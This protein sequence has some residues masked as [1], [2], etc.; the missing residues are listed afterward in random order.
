MRLKDAVEGCSNGI[1]GDEPKGDANDT[2]VIRVADFDRLKRKTLPHQ[3][4]RSVP[5]DQR[6]PREL[7]PGDL[8]I[9]KSGGG[10][11]QPVGMVVEFEGETGSVC[12]N[13][14]A[15]MRPREFA[16]GRFLT[17]LHAHLYDRS[18]TKLSIKQST[19]IQNLDSGAYLAER[20]FLPPTVEQIA[21]ASYLDAETVRIDG[22][23][24]AKRKLLDSLVELKSARITEILTGAADN[25]VP[26]G[27]VWIPRI[28]RDWTLKRLKHLGQ[29]R[30]GLAKGKKHDAS[31]ETLE[32]PYM[33]VA[34]VQDGHIDLSN[35]ATLE[36]AADDVERYSLAVGDVLMNEGGDYDKLGRGAVWEGKISP[37][38]H[39]NH[40]FAVR[41]DDVTWAP[42]ISALTRTAYAKFYFMNNSK[43]STNLAS[44]S[45]TNVK[46]WPVV[47]PP[48]DVR[49]QLLEQLTA[50]LKR[51]DDLIVHVELEL[52]AL[53]ELRAATITDAVLGRIDVRDYMKK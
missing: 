8:L 5:F 42:W 26:T 28:P 44:I 2:P 39:Q 51:A 3:T 15:R 53:A 27:D 6:S 49:D 10:E 46:E 19:G 36:V 12:S 30:S 34:N 11:L 22:L 50:E 25:L 37:C 40:V 1:W 20:C 17:F 35:V 48:E 9:E 7:H 29:V 23:I 16:H 14:V 24:E 47:L 31:T 13:F 18:L 38:L 21:I 41:L 43:Q 33:R 4:V 32:L 52:E 45:Q